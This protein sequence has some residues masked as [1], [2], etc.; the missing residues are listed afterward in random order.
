MK[1]DFFSLTITDIVSILEEIEAERK[2]NVGLSKKLQQR[3]AGKDKVL[4]VPTSGNPAI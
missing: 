1:F 3:R 4:K 2:K